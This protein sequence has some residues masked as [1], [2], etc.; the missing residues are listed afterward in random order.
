VEGVRGVR[1]LPGAVPRGHVRALRRSGQTAGDR[2]TLR[3]DQGPDRG[4]DGHRRR[5]LRAGPRAR[6]RAVGCPRGRRQADSGVARAASVLDRSAADDRVNEVLLR[7]LV[8]AVIGI[9]RRRGVDFA[10]AEDAVQDALVEAIRTW[11][12]TP[13]RDPRGWLVTVAWRRHIYAVRS[14][15]ARPVQEA[16]VAVEPTPA[17]D[18]VPDSVDTLQLVFLC[19]RPSLTSAAAVAL[20]LR[21][22][23][24]LTTRQIEVAYLVLQ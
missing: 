20:T 3:R 4:L 21:S 16:Q 12:K 17:L 11:P 15:C 13:P 24:W 2:R 9:L 7:E 5:L 23:V 18:T 6:R 10:A 19:A 8:P 1:R 14:A 22:F